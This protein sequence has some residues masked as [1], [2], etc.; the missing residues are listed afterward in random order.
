MIIRIILE[1]TSSVYRVTFTNI[2]LS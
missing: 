1:D 2:V